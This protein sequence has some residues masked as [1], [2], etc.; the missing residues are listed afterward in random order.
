[1]APLSLLPDSHLCHS[2]F[3]GGRKTIFG[4]TLSLC[5][6]EDNSLAR[7]KSNPRARVRQ[8]RLNEASFGWRGR[9]LG[10]RTPVRTRGTSKAARTRGRIARKQ[11]IFKLPTY[12]VYTACCGC[13]KL[14]RAHEK[15][16]KLWVEG[17]F[18]IFCR[19]WAICKTEPHPVLRKK[20]EFEEPSRWPNQ[21]MQPLQPS[22]V[23]IGYYTMQMHTKLASHLIEKSCSYSNS[24]FLP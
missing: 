20:H 16:H 23:I 24:H 2:T 15:P 6:R 22:T 13:S 21:P 10:A 12:S 18:F 8:A 7:L 19:E 4:I 14:V 5:A 17:S 1:M 3:R 11:S 9:G